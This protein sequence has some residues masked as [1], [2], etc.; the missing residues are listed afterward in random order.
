MHP[1]KNLPDI[2]GCYYPAGVLAEHFREVG[3]GLGSVAHYRGVLVYCRTCRGIY[4]LFLLVGYH[5]H[6]YMPHTLGF[7]SFFRI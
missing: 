6:L 2:S 4:G 1:W 3:M 5:D 7:L